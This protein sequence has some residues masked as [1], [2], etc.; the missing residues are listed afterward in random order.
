MEISVLTGQGQ[1]IGFIP[2]SSVGV[3]TPRQKETQSV[4]IFQISGPMDSFG[5][6]G[7]SFRNID[8]G[9]DQ[10]ENKGAIAELQRIGNLGGADQDRMNE[11]EKSKGAKHEKAGLDLDQFVDDAF[12]VPEGIKLDPNFGQHR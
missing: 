5:S 3:G 4:G 6:V 1:R 11:C 2:V 9:S 8:S 12:A 10:F 7:L